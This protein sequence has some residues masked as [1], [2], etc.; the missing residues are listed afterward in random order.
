MERGSTDYKAWTTQISWV[1]DTRV[2]DT[3]HESMLLYFLVR[4]RGGAG[5]CLFQV[6]SEGACMLWLFHVE[7]MP[8]SWDD[9]W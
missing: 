4:E 5:G 6:L 1:I 2:F 8:G 7:M 3:R 9:A